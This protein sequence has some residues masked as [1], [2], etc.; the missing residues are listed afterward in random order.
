MKMT[1]L[2]G[3]ISSAPNFEL[4]VCLDVIFIIFVFHLLFL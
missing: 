3:K 1:V 4:D 2:V